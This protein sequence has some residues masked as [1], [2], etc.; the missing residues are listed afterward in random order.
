MINDF[1]V[2]DRSGRI[3]PMGFGF[4]SVG[5]DRANHTTIARPLIANSIIDIIQSIEQ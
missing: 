3:I 4:R 5:V 2:M 1:A